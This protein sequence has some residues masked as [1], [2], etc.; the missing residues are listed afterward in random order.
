MS[1]RSPGYADDER[2]VEV[3]AGETVSI[4]AVLVRPGPLSGETTAVSGIHDSLTTKKTT[5]PA[6]P[7]SPDIPPSSPGEIIVIV[8]AVLIGYAVAKR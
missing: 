4:A 6:P 2:T 7:A 8:A 1:I 3:G 5:A